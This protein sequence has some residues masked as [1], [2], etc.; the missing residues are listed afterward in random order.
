MSAYCLILHCP[1]R[2]LLHLTGRAPA[3]HQCLGCRRPAAD[4]GAR[5]TPEHCLAGMPTNALQL[6][7]DYL[8]QHCCIVHM[9]LGCP[10]ATGLVAA[11]C[12]QYMWHSQCG[13]GVQDVL[14]TVWYHDQCNVLHL[15][16]RMQQTRAM[17][18]SR[19]CSATSKQSNCPTASSSRHQILSH[20]HNRR[21][22][23]R[24][25]SGAQKQ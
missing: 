7:P 4:A 23:R 22:S 12:W 2:P 14:P 25:T 3:G 6:P 13:R 24:R 19:A 18:R 11:S 9:P 20:R 15:R 5:L 1:M 21:H 8:L 16:R 10:H 17:Q